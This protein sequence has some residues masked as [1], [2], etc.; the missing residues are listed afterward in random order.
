MD[1]NGFIF[2]LDATLALIPIFI[3]L[4]AVVST[5]NPDIHSSEQI[6]LTHSAQ[7]ALEN[8]ARIQNGTES[9]IFQKMAYI[10][11]LNNNSDNSIKETGRI[12]G[13]YLNKTLGNLKY[14][15]TEISE[16]NKTIAFN[17]DMKNA[18]DISV[19]FKSYENYIFKLYVWN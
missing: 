17:G 10:L 9:N 11:S 5:G 1:N 14:N 19:G 3:I 13:S 18:K 4:A 16:L 12:S 7:D 8:M 2:T 6:R 15:L